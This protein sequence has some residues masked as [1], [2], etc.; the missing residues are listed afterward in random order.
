[1]QGALISIDGNN[2]FVK[3]IVGGKN[4]IKGDFNRAI[5]AKRQPGSSFKPIVYLAA[6]MQNIPMNTVL[7]D[8]EYKVG[9]WSPRN[10]GNDHKGNLTMLKAL[11]LS[12]NITSVKL[13][14]KIGLNKAIKVWTDSGA[15][16]ENI[17]K[18]YTLALGSIT[19][20]PI[21]MATF[22]ASLSNGGY[23]VEPQFI[24]KIENKNGEIIYE[25]TAKKTKIYEKE[26]VALITF[27]LQKAV[28]DGTG[29][30]ATVYKNGNLIPM[31]GKTGTSNG[32]VSAWF[33]GY[34]PNLATVVYV[35]YDDNKSMKKGMTGSKT[36]IPIWKSY[37]QE[38]VNIPNYNI[39]NF[40]F[41]L[42]GLLEG[43]LV[44][45]DIDLYN[46][47]LDSDGNNVSDALFKTGTQPVEYEN[48]NI[49]YYGGY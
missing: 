38:V 19:T 44:K 26:D 48:D 27:M 20:T 29:R 3:A 23:K 32:Y 35:G 37:M 22:Y 6:L 49:F 4:Y 46:G 2:G 41:I 21:E 13:L 31:A 47:L 28:T 14:E 15:S 11:E 25:A 17:S 43:T 45:E 8:R 39:G 40:E 24:Y 16:N 33:T 9:K 30:T 1:M 12:N 10:Y 5:Y 36:A 34:T 7:E 18:D 42:D